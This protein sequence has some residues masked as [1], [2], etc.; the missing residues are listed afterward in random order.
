MTNVI[1]REMNVNIHRVYINCDDDIFIG[2]FDLR[3]HDRKDMKV[4]MDNLKKVE[5]LQEVTQVM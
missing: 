3:V 5:G 1:S 4:I 2:K